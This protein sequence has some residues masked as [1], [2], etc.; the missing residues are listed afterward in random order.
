MIHKLEFRN[1][2]CVGETTSQAMCTAQI[3]FLTKDV[4]QLG[5]NRS[6]EEDNIN[7]KSSSY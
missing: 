7:I 4:F 3:N 1:N 6:A 5:Q 2:K